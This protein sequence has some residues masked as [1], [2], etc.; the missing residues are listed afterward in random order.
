MIYYKDEDDISKRIA[1]ESTDNRKVTL[2]VA[3][4]GVMSYFRRLSLEHNNIM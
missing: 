3:I 2:R 4:T 1:P